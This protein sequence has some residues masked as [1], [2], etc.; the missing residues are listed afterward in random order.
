M[1]INTVFYKK[2]GSPGKQNFI[3]KFLIGQSTDNTL[4]AKC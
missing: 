4:C 3:Q 2:L 1:T